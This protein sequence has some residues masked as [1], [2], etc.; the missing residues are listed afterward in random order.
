MYVFYLSLFLGKQLCLW[1]IFL[2][3]YKPWSYSHS[4]K[5]LWYSGTFYFFKAVII[6]LLTADD[7]FRQSWR[8]GSLLFTG[9][10]ERWLLFYIIAYAKER[11]KRMCT[12]RVSW[13]FNDVNE[14]SMRIKAD[15]ASDAVYKAK[16]TILRNMP[17][18]SYGSMKNGKIFEV[19][20]LS[21]VTKHVFSLF[22]AQ[23]V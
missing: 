16:L 14:N 9:L 23:A 15:S 4:P 19:S 13:R 10:S 3:V 11:E 1:N 17:T 2:K 22:N 7:P 12:Y 5:V 20:S 18:T 21:G 8:C 6:P